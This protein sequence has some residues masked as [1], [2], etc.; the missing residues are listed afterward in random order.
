MPKIRFAVFDG[1]KTVKIL[2]SDQAIARHNAR[3]PDAKI[4]YLQ[5]FFVKQAEQNSRL[6]QEI[7]T[8]R[9]MFGCVK[10]VSQMK[11]VVRI[12]HKLQDHN[13]PFTFSVIQLYRDNIL[14]VPHNKTTQWQAL[15]QIPSLTPPFRILPP[16]GG[17]FLP[18]WAGVT[19]TSWCYGRI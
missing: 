14:Q 9:R 5:R 13:D 15:K 17:I 4:S 8:F 3:F 7:R 2:N 1:R 12:C 6:N 16:V 10:L 18:L 11:R 19:P